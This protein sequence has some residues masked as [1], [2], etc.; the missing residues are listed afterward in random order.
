MFIS[1]TSDNDD[2]YGEI[3]D[4][5]GTITL[6]RPDRRNA[7]SDAMIDGLASLLEIMGQS[8]EVGVI[9]LTGAGKAFC[10]G[11]DVQDFDAKGGEGFGQDEVDQGAVEAQRAAQSATVGAIYSSS[12][13][14]IA[15]IPG[16]AAGAGL[17]LALAAD[18]RIGSERAVM[19]TAFAGV[20][21]AGDFGVAW[22]LNNLVGPAKAR[23]LLMLNPRISAQ[24]AAG[25]GLLNWVVPED[26]LAG[27]TRALAEQLAHGPSQALRS[28]K[29]NLVR[30]P[31]QDLDESMHDEVP[32]HKATGLTEDHIGAIRA[33]VEKRKPTFGSRREQAP[34][35]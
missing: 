26:E 13:P 20:G 28:M 35:V 22:L 24:D 25:L 27:R 21:L 12:K 3:V 4:G 10:S 1:G 17:G 33:F 11:G 8:D 18:F 31:K 14:V 6:N 32:L 9:V 23:E 34:R 15:A 29:A 30:A 5:I 2:V 19:A 7:I 16:A